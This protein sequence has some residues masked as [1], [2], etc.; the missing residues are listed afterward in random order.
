MF[1][2]PAKKCPKIINSASG[3]HTLSD[4]MMEV[5]M[6]QLLEM[7]LGGKKYMYLQQLP[8]EVAGNTHGSFN[9]F[10]SR[11]EVVQAKRSLG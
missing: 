9:R 1:S 11:P 2:M 7:G 4:I 10:W 6:V 8:L 3:F 5:S